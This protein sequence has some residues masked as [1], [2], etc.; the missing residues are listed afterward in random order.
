[1]Q[2]LWIKRATFDQY[3]QGHKDLAASLNNLGWLHYERMAEPPETLYGRDANSNYQGQ[4]LRLAKQFR[5][6]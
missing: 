5:Q 2:R 1:M 3:P 6:A 4:T